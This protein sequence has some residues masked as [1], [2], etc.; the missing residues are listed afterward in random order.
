[1]IKKRKKPE[2][3]IVPLVDVLVV[4]I[5]FFLVTMQ[6]A[7]QKVLNLT[8]PEIETAG[9]NQPDFPIIIA[10]DKD[11]TLYLNKQVLKE[12]E[13]PQAVKM[14]ANFT[15]KQRVLLVADRQTPLERITGIMD[16]CRRNGL[17]NIQLQS[18]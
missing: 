5:F 15:K 18:R 17:D 7:D 14:I 12:E 3:S 8:L 9:E 10:V 13:F 16:V 4:L 11:D 2:F 1:M 6:F